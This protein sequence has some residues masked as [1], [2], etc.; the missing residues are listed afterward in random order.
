MNGKTVLITGISGFIANHCAVEL[1]NA[2]Y[3][4]R[5][6]LRSLGRAE[7]VKDTLAKHADATNLGL[8]EADLESDAGWDEALAGCAHV[9]H[10]ASPFPVSQ[11]K[12]EQVLIRPAVEG[13]LRVLR[14]AR[15]AE[16]ERFVQTS[17]MAA[18]Q[19]GHPH[20]RTAPFTEAD[21]T[22][23]DAPGVTPYA[24]SKTLAERA[25]RDFVRE[26]AGALH[27]SSVNPGFVLGPV[28]SADI[29]TSAEI[30]ELMLKGKYPGTPRVSFACV[31][32]RDVARMHRLALEAEVPSGGRYLGASQCL[33]MGEI[34]KA[35]RMQLGDVARRVPSRDLPDWVVKLVGVFDPKARQ[36]LPELGREVHVDNTLTR[37]TLQMTFMPATDAAAAMAQSLIDLNVVS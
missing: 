29:R 37:E 5:G 34:A 9:L 12:D 20:S 18:V 8:A 35:I 23:V 19:Y 13:T 10:V 2:G 3:R 26:H 30:I 15:G 6:T 31:D 24:K 33:W 17:S 14:A 4:V 27:Y 1:L 21:W 11:P 28:L 16:V 7:Q 32:V 36:L 22:L 25:A